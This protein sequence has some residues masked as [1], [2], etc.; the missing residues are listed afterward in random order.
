VKG[1]CSSRNYDSWVGQLEVKKRGDERAPFM[2]MMNFNAVMSFNNGTEKKEVQLCSGR[3]GW[4][5]ILWLV[6]V[7]LYV[8]L[9][10]GGLMWRDES[11]RNLPFPGNTDPWTPRGRRQNPNHYNAWPRS[12]HIGF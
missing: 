5:F 7:S 8:G 2:Q 6:P 9:A 12:S 1:G 11:S 10:P 4:V 3:Y